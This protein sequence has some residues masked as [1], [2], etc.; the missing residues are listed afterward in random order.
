[1]FQL[2]GFRCK[3]CVDSQSRGALESAWR[4]VESCSEITYGGP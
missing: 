3:A 4:A 1:M 2:S